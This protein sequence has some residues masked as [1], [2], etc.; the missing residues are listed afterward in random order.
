MIKKAMFVSVLM[1]LS[2]SAFAGY[3]GGGKITTILE[4]GWASDDFY[5]KVDYSESTNN[6]P[7]TDRS[8]FIIFKKDSMSV[9]RF[10]GIKTIA[11]LAFTTGKTIWTYTNS[12][13][14]D[15]TSSMG[16]D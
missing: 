1:F 6:H 15:D 4:G 12:D 16:I 2:S 13:R 9:E 5:I 10:K 11:F 3:C 7:G 14:C 8:G